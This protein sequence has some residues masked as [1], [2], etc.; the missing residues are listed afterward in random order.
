MMKKKKKN[1]VV[2]CI[3]CGRDTDNKSGACDD[4]GYDRPLLSP[5]EE[6]YVR[7]GYQIVTEDGT[8]YKGKDQE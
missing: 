2:C 7:D 4:C 3:S 8:K 6:S 1:K 5:Q